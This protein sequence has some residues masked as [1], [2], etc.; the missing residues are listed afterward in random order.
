MKKIMEIIRLFE[1][2]DM[3]LRNQIFYSIDQLNQAILQELG[4]YNS[5]P[6]Q[7]VLGKVILHVL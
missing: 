2:G 5:K 3:I 7:L 6:M 4:K 1:K